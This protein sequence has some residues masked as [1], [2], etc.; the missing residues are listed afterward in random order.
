MR[1]KAKTSSVNRSPCERTFLNRDL[2]HSFSKECCFGLTSVEVIFQTV[3][4]SKL[5]SMQ[6]NFIFRGSSQDV[7]DT[8]RMLLTKKPQLEVNQRR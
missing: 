2:Q 1:N 4:G 7:D 5:K 8:I 3:W 6:H